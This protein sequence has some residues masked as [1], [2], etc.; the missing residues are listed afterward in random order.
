MKL[1]FEAYQPV[2]IEKPILSPFY[3]I[4][5]N[6]ILSDELGTEFDLEG[7]ENIDIL[8]KALV[9]NTYGN[10]EKVQDVLN[11]LAEHG[12]IKE[13]NNG[14]F[15]TGVTVSHELFHQMQIEIFKYYKEGSFIYNLIENEV[16]PQQIEDW[17][18]KCFQYTY[19]AER[20][21]NSVV[22]NVKNSRAER[23]FWE[24]FRDDEKNHWKIYTNI[25]KHFSFDI[26][27][28]KNS[29]YD[30]NV[31]NFVNF[32]CETGE[33]SSYEY[34]S[35][36]FMMELPPTVENIE[37]DLQF[38]TLIKKYNLPKNTLEP[39]F[40]HASYNEKSEHCEIWYNVLR[41]RNDYTQ[42]ELNSI[43]ESSKKHCKLAYM[44]NRVS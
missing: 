18:K 4:E 5:N 40:N 36:L 42:D 22:E 33:R 6:L 13:Q 11:V 38:G 26:E 3:K 32:L 43:I 17:I 21:I 19:S 1:N 31:E 10:I 9:S 12:F 28:L 30:S 27:E 37:D 7:I 8:K 29:T 15:V 25:C 20:H 16:K 35:L 24:S 14:E 44:W 34:A 2:K 23:L 41:S 39:L